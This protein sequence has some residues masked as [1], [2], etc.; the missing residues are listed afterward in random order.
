[1]MYKKIVKQICDAL[2][3][4]YIKNRVDAEVTLYADCDDSKPVATVTVNSDRKYKLWCLVAV[5]GAVLLA[6]WMLCRVKKLIEK[7]F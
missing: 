4:P 2:D 3:R 1:M 5:V 6:M 7:L